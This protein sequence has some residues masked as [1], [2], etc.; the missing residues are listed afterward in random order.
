MDG[1]D[2][3]ANHE[4]T[5]VQPRPWIAAASDVLLADGM[6][7]VIRSLNPGDREGVLALH[8]GVSQDTLRLRFFTPSPAAGR[9]YVARLFDESNDESVALVA[10]LRGRI[11]A[12]ATA[13][14]LSR[15]RAEVAFLVSDE[16]RGRGL[17]SL[18]LEHLAALCRDQAVTRF[19]AEVLADNYGMLG[20]FQAAGF[21]VTRRNQDGEVSVELR[22]EVSPA[23]IDAADRRE[24]RSEARSLRP[25]LYPESVA[26][27]GVRRDAGLG[28][29]VLEA[30]RSGG[31]SG[32]LYVVQPESDY[33][34][35]LPTCPS[36]AAI[37]EAVDLVVVVV[38]NSEVVSAMADATAAGAGAAIVVSSG[39]AGPDGLGA[40][41]RRELLRTARAHS[42]RV[43]GPDSQG[44]LSQGPGMSLNATFARALPGPGGLAIASQ[45]G[46]VGL[47]LLDLARDLGVGV[48]SFVSLGAKLDVSSNDLL[49]AWMD[50]DQVA[51]AA[52][53]LESF[54]NA[55]KFART[56]RRF[57]ER[58]PLLGVVGGRS[59]GS[60]IGVDA[61]FAQAGVIPCS[62]ATE[63]AETAA[64]LLG[65]PMPAGYRVGVVTNAG[66]MGTLVA[67]L[68]DAEGLSVPKLSGE[69]WAAVQRAVP[70]AVRTNNPVD[71]GADLSPA[72]LEAGVRALL[73]LPELDALVV[74]LVPTSLA[75]PDALF[76]ALSRT[77]AESDRPLLLVASSGAEHGRPDG[78]T[79]YRN[80][81]AAV[82]AL[83]RTMRY[84]AW[85]RVPAEDPPAPLG[86]RAAFAHAWSIQRLAARGGT[87]EWLPASA[88]A[89]LLGPY[90]VDH[91]G[92]EARDSD[93]A[94]RAA[95]AIGFPVVV[96][97]ADPTVVHKTDRGLVRAGLLTPAD[98]VAAVD[99]F[100]AELGSESVDV[101]VQPVLAGVEVACGV[102]RDP[103]FGPLI[104]IAA[105]G[106]ATEVWKDEVYLVPPVS[107]ADV[108]RAMRGLRLWPL[109]EGYRGSE[110]VDVEAL[111]SILVGV[112]QLVVDVP[113]VSDL[114]LNPLLVTPDGV[115]CVDVKVRLQV[116]DTL[117]A[118]IP[119]R[120]R[121]PL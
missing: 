57:A 51:A 61:L 105:G 102:I 118:G 78:V 75:D 34:A 37:G 113:E 104:R 36:L 92:V 114:D 54:G 60:S 90:G 100:R 98:V 71:L 64:L 76:G 12:L 99:A 30:L 82:G 53:H 88:S 50:D 42:L 74:V 45:S 119:R 101:R 22:T 18:L 69:G 13:E 46:G 56:A 41:A 109:L 48:R 39:L 120:L 73:S 72:A 44:L 26:V 43:V 95:A 91:V 86:V 25:L 93:D 96:K 28:N 11:A 80:A 65:Q 58:K 17:G 112:G 35:G 3:T 21:T 59:T 110:V 79:V 23:A 38:P 5:T 32:R 67:D 10:E 16:D 7:A 84:A 29:A 89:E 55:L 115:H 70:R 108:G 77:G 6:I 66:G 106:V 85:R 97:V 52:L 117:D 49:A 94:C 4:P 40:A 87:A 81:E 9:A 121:S 33:V 111:Q 83:A 24:W 107:R 62:S 19:E 103:V 68:A 63:V 31:F 15:E 14:L 47:T 27:V 2:L 1:Q 116:C 20:V 8:E